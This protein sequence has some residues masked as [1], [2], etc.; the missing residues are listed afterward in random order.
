MQDLRVCQPL[1]SVPPRGGLIGPIRSHQRRA[2][3][4]NVMLLSSVVGDDVGSRNSSGDMEGRL[5]GWTMRPVYGLATVIVYY[6]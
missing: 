2:G 3:A 4:A 5:G 1:Y 6:Y